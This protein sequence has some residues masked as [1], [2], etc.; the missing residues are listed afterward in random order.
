MMAG[1]WMV[2]V[3]VLIGVLLALALWPS[4]PASGAEKSCVFFTGLALGPGLVSALYYFWVYILNASAAPL[5]WIELGIAVA[6]L[7]VCLLTAPRRPLSSLRPPEDPVRR[8]YL[9]W[10]F[11]AVLL[12]GATVM[13]LLSLNRPHGEWD[14]W[15]IWNQR[16]RMLL[17]GKECFFMSMRFAN[18]GD[19]PLLVPSFIARCW[20][21]MGSLTTVIPA[22][23]ALLFS[24]GT[25]GL[26]VSALRLT[27]G[28]NQGY[29]GGLFLLGSYFFIRMSAR[30]YADE[31]LAHNI[32]G[33]LIF[34]CLHDALR[35][36]NRSWLVLAGLF[37]GLSV[38]TKN[39]G[40]LFFLSL[41][42][43]LGCYWLF[44]RSRRALGDVVALL[45]AAA[46]IVLMVQYFKGQVGIPSDLFIGGKL[47]DNLLT[48]AR[49][50]QVSKAFVHEWTR[51]NNW[52]LLPYL[53]LLWPLAARP[54]L[55]REALGGVLAG[56][57][58]LLCLYAGYFA[59]YIIT[60]HD[61]TIHLATSLERLCLHL[62][63]SM[64]FLPLFAYVEGQRTQKGANG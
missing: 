16:A 34:L 52:G 18:H 13:I 44:H 7:L 6:L 1:A 48:L 57:A 14:S 64:A 17:L 28:R 5:P 38:W 19:Y 62:W 29:I 9:A 50:A 21:V 23:T 26:L 39:E 61:L 46:P 27:R 24:A 40:S 8:P 15:V 56:A 35:P 3:A 37:A 4:R 36:R 53:L 10:A 51:T 47:K 41:V 54:V 31:T 55:P 60:P 42:A 49:Y 30:Q 45:L 20:G 2:F 33:C 11:W 43:G 58:C 63:P 25:I 32:M 22:A 12:M 59:V